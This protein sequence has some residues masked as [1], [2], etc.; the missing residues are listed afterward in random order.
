MGKNLHHI[1]PGHYNPYQEVIW[2][3]GQTLS[4]FDDDNLIPDYG[5]GDVTTKDKAI[6]AFFEGGRPANGFKEVLERYY[7]ITPSVQL[8]GPKSF[9]PLIRE[10]IKVVQNSRSYHILII[11]ADGQVDNVKDTSAAIVEASNYPISILMVGVGDGP[12]DLME[13][14]D[15]QLPERKFDNFQFVPYSKTMERAENREVTFSVAALQEI[16][17]QYSAIKKL[18]L[19]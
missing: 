14:F 10:A 4:A 3:L 17:D 7:Q 8:S 6:F 18:G 5:F 12:W 9:T 15:D 13:E 11:I 1:E 19:L 16:P 2:I